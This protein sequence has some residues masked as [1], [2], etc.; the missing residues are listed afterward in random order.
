MAPYQARKKQL[1]KMWSGK[2]K[3][4]GHVQVRFAN[5]GKFAWTMFGGVETF[6]IPEALKHLIQHFS[7]G[8]SV[9]FSNF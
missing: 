4:K 2:V 3:K 9:C 5:F 1:S 7:E 6:E 8:L